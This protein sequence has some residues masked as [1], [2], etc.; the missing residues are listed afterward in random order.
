MKTIIVTD[1]LAL[2]RG[3]CRVNG[4]GTEGRREPESWPR[5]MRSPRRD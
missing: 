3:K 2:D 4:A 1:T 5:K